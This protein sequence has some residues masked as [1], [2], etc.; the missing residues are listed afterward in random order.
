M[1]HIWLL[2]IAFSIFLVACGTNNPDTN[3]SLTESNGDGEWSAH[4]S[5]LAGL[6]VGDGGEFAGIMALSGAQ[7]AREAFNGDSAVA[8]SGP[9]ELRSQD[10]DRQVIST[11]SISVQVEV[12]SGAVVAVRTI[13]EGLGGYV[14]V[15]STSGS[16]DGGYATITIRVP[17]ASFYHVIDQ[18]SL[19]GK[20]DSKHIGSDD[21]T[22]EFI[23]LN[24]R[25]KTSL[26]EEQSL[27]SLLDKATGVADVLAI[28]RQLSRI[29]SDV[30][31]LQ[32]QLNYLERRVDM[33]TITVSL[34]SLWDSLGRPPYVTLEIQPSDVT[35]AVN[36][37]KALVGSLDGEL[38]QVIVTTQD[39][40]ERASIVL[41]VFR[42]GFAAALT[43]IEGMG[44]VTSKRLQEGSGTGPGAPEP[45][46]EPDATMEITLT[47]AEGINLLIAIVAPVGGVSFVALMAALLIL[48][49]RTGRGR[50][51]DA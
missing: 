26:R 38:D 3:D 41:R 47:E 36:D 48:S 40:N 19:L 30:E 46:D 39:G 14:E 35:R 25:L 34:Y 15:L 44:D 32:G 45:F 49:Y 24:A 4:D 23:D 37:I 31:R 13:A 12:V 11:A 33:A 2:A 28:E 50:R 27:L 21:V 6:P 18:I 42:T 17:Q 8:E 10:V 1:K 22:E 16:D 29:R 43:T 7:A 20:V 51:A 5:G 9:S